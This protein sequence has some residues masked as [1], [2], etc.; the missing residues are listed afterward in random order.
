MNK[1][2]LA[3]LIGAL[4]A[5]VAFA[6]ETMTTTTVTAPTSSSSMNR[7]EFADADFTVKDPIKS[8]H[9]FLGQSQTDNGRMKGIA[10]GAD[11]EFFNHRIAL[12][13]NYVN[14]SKTDGYPASESGSLYVAGNAVRFAR[15]RFMLTGDIAAGAIQTGSL[16]NDGTGRDFDGFYGANVTVNYNQEIGLRLSRRISDML[17]T[18]DTLSLVGYY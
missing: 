10:I 16:F 2:V 7:D 8:T 14:Y 9:L 11:R 1:P 3:L 13:I 15:K 18:E 4:C 12:G 5:N 6:E 17:G